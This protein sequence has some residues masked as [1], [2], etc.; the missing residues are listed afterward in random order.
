MPPIPVKVPFRGAANAAPFIAPSEDF[1]P[2]SRLRNFF[3]HDVDG[4]RL[5]GGTRPGARALFTQVMGGGRPVQALF[6]V[7]RAAQVTGFVVPPAGDGYQPVRSI[8]GGRSAIAGPIAG[9]LFAVNNVPSYDYAGALAGQGGPA[10]V[11]VSALAVS[12]DGVYFAAAANHVVGGFLRATIELR[13]VSDG[14]LVWSHVI[15]QASVNRF[16]TG[17]FFTTEAVWACTNG[18]LHGRYLSDNTAVHTVAPIGGIVGDYVLDWA[19]KTVAGVCYGGTPFGAGDGTERFLV[20]FNGTAVGSPGSPGPYIEDGHYASQFRSG[21]MLFATNARAVLGIGL[22]PIV[23]QSYGGRAGD[24][25]YQEG[26]HGYWRVS[27]RSAYGPRGCLINGLARHTD[28][29]VVFTR[30][31]V[32]CGPTSSFPPDGTVVPT[33]SL[34]AINPDGTLKWEADPV[35]SVLESGLLGYL[36]DCPVSGG[37][38]V[39]N[40]P[41]IGPLAIDAAGDVY[42]GGRQT[43][44][45]FSAFKVRGTDGGRVWATNLT[46]SGAVVRGVAIDPADG[47]P[48]FVGDRNNGWTGSGGASRHLWKL[49]ALTGAVINSLDLPSAASALAVVCTPSL[50]LYGSDQI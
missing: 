50:A 20:A 38:G 2:Q 11:S 29:S 35:I 9:N 48:V 6:T 18:Y 27:E 25:T 46:G 47:H 43:D 41:T 33:V 39:T 15:S 34:T 26:E 12:R 17:L 44:G 36:N 28:G 14:S 16:V 1:A 3:P 23:Q 19:G 31:N 32:G 10:T 8:T 42:T 21:V 49:N 5:R 7:T 40:E 22:S 24:S 30:T 13:L 4:D 37:S 45:L